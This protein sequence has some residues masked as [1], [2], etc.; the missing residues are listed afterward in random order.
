MFDPVQKIME[1]F[2]LHILYKFCSSTGFEPQPSNLT[3]CAI[4]VIIDNTTTT[5]LL[6][7]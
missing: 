3:P 4:R 7:Q 2:V 1:K 5:Q 6:D